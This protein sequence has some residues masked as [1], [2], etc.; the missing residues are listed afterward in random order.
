MF[1]ITIIFQTSTYYLLFA[2][3]GVATLKNDQ[4]KPS[5]FRSFH[6]VVKEN[7]RNILA[8]AVSWIFR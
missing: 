3:H 4:I 6:R 8:L 1:Y 5:L 7:V 2:H